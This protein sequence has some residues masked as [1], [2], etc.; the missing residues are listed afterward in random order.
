MIISGWG[1]LLIFAANQA[2]GQIIAPFPAFGLATITVLNIAAYLMLLGIYNSAR[3]VSTTNSLRKYI[4]E[5]A[6]ESKLLSFIGKAQM[7]NEI[8]K[9]V[10]KIS[11][12]KT[13]LERNTGSEVQ[14]DEKELKN[15]LDDVIREVKKHPD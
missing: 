3:L 7:E 6:L 5:Q 8:Q 13:L 10:K 4:H 15:Y 1:L 9:T 14:L 11:Q 2:A 12:E